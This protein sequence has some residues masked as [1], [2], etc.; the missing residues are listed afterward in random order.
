MEDISGKFR[1][2][3]WLNRSRL[4]KTEFSKVQNKMPD[5][6]L[7]MIVAPA[8]RPAWREIAASIMT[9]CVNK[10]KDA[11]IVVWATVKSSIPGVEAST[12]IPA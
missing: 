4:E 8:E 12:I 1:T 5:K 6:I 2:A 3:V 7:I 9:E 10:M 11:K